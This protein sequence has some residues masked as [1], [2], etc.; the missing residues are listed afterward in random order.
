MP[1]QLLAP[2]R[3][4][5]FVLLDVRPCI[6]FKF[7]RYF[8]RTC[9]LHMQGQRIIPA[10][11]QV[12]AQ[13]KQ[14]SDCYIAH[15]GCSSTLNMKAKCASKPPIAFQKNKKHYINNNSALQGNRCESKCCFL[16]QVSEPW[17]IVC[18]EIRL[19][20]QFK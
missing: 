10:K 14:S 19:K 12:K 8:G 15:P 16:W 2:R 6:S 9:R 1:V 20:K 18:C 17:N 11:K 7:N 3:V 4:M 5:N 13:S